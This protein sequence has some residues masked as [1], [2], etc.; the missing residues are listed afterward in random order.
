MCG[1]SFFQFFERFVYLSGNAQKFSKFGF[2][3]KTEGFWLLNNKYRNDLLT[4]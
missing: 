4:M 1:K 3:A 2:L